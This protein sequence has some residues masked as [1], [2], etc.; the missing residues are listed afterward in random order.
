MSTLGGRPGA[1]FCPGIHSL[2]Q[3]IIH[4]QSGP[5]RPAHPASLRL[6]AVERRKHSLERH[7]AITALDEISNQGPVDVAIRPETHPLATTVRGQ[8]GAGTAEQRTSVLFRQSEC[9]R[10]S[11]VDTFEGCERSS[12]REEVWMSPGACLPG[13]GK[14]EA[15]LAESRYHSLFVH[16]VPTDSRDSQIAAPTTG[17]GTRK[18]S[19]NP[20]GTTAPDSRSPP[21]CCREPRQHV[22]PLCRPQSGPHR[23]DPG[24]RCPA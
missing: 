15:Q 1:T 19:C 22:P 20:L 24:R 2:L 16:G 4:E 13:F 12:A 14:R 9:K 8:E 10:L 3:Q 7:K 21:R 11:P 23:T 18:S 17:T 5:G 6:E